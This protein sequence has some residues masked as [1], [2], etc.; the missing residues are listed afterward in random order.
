VDAEI[1]PLTELRDVD[2]AWYVGLDACGTQIG[3]ALW[4]GEAVEQTNGAQVVGLFRLD[5]TKPS[6]MPEPIRGTP[7]YLILAMT[8]ERQLRMK[9]QNLITGLPVGEREAIS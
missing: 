3:D 6:T 2:L 9:P 5:F 4:H 8:P 7:V 1:T